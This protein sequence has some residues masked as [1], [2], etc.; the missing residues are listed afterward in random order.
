MDEETGSAAYRYIEASIAAALAGEV[1]AVVTGE[2]EEA[3]PALLER[4]L[5]EESLA[6][7]PGA[8]TLGA[9]GQLQ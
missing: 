6:G 5:A 8:S 2:G 4:F 7:L 3:L 1:D 9:E